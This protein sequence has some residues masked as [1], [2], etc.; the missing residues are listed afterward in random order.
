MCQLLGMEDSYDEI[1]NQLGIERSGHI[2]FDD[3]VRCRMGLVAEI[4]QE[5]QRE[6]HLCNPVTL[7]SHRNI[8]IPGSS[9]NSLGKLSIKRHRQ[10]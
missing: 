2:S 7:Q 1:T 10:D 4:E 9:D 6:R 8:L 5:K 3:F